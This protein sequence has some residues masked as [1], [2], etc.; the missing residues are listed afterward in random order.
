MSVCYI[1]GIILTFLKRIFKVTDTYL[2]NILYLKVDIKDD[3]IW[4]RPRRENKTATNFTCVCYLI[5]AAVNWLKRLLLDLLFLMALEVT[6]Q[7][8]FIFLFQQRMAIYFGIWDL[9]HEFQI[10]L[11]ISSLH[12]AIC[13]K[14]DLLKK[15]LFEKGRDL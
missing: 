1:H 9:V 6:A 2:Y 3:N 14:G 11:N 7:N 8:I 4:N 10:R 15:T 12:K 5:M 13:M